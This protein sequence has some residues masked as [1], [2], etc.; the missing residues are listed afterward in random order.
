MKRLLSVGALLA[1]TIAASAHGGGNASRTVSSSRLVES[2]NFRI[3]ATIATPARVGKALGVTFRITNVSKQ[4]RSIELG[5]PENLWFVVHIPNGEKYDSRFPEHLDIGG[6]VDATRLKPGESV[7]RRPFD[8]RIR[9]SGPLRITPGFNRSALPA[10]EVPVAV[11]S[12][13]LPGDSAAIADVVASTGH[14]LDDC[15]PAKPGVPVIGEI[16][17]PKNSV[18][19]MRARCSITL[20][21]A[22]GFIVAQAFVVV[23]PLYRGVHLQPPYEMF[24]WPKGFVKFEVIA[25]QFVVTPK[26]AISVDSASMRKTRGGKARAPQGQWTASGW[27]ANGDE[28]CGATGGTGNY[29]GPW[30]VFASVCRDQ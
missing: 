17:A 12:G 11:P 10:V 28:R 3:T 13:R 29:I 27:K 4:A 21:R 23:P 2:G 19:P 15:R 18:P 20:R 7:M 5:Y 24:T 16:K 30:V 6:P 22:R 8:L 26:Q 1:L 14:L 25:W 9:W